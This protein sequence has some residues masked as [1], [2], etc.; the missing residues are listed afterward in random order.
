M[1]TVIHLKRRRRTPHTMR[2]DSAYIST[3]SISHIAPFP[4]GMISNLQGCICLNYCTLVRQGFLPSNWH[5]PHITE[6]IILQ[7]NSA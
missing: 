4:Y 5:N 2:K 7:M 6:F 3:F 1:I